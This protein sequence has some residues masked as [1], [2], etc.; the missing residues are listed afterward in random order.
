MPATGKSASANAASRESHDVRT[1][2][3]DL[4]AFLGLARCS[5]DDASPA[6]TRM[7]PS[8]APRHSACVEKLPGSKRSKSAQ[9]ASKPK[10]APE[11][12]VKKMMLNAGF[13]APA[14]AG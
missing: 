14:L 8:S 4:Q 9:S 2:A 1:R 6:A 11:A 7:R 12:T 10:P 5:V 3:S 13:I